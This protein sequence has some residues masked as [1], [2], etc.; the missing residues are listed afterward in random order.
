MTNDFLLVVIP[1]SA[2]IIGCISVI[3]DI[4]DRKNAR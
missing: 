2:T 4:K 3:S 1:V